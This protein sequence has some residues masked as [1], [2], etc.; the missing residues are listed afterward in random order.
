MNT[1]YVDTREKPHAITRI[2]AEFERRG[3]EIV[4]KKLDVGD[5]MLSPD[6][7]VTVDRKQNLGE[8]CG[9]LTWEHERFQRELRRAT[10]AGVTVYV[11]VEHGGLIRSL[12]DVAGW[13]NPRCKSSPKALNGEGLYKRMLTYAAKYGVRWRFCDKRQTGAEILRL[14]GASDEQICRNN[15]GA[16][17][18]A[19]A[20]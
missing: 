11:L 2:I 14:L 18:D 3:L 6:A 9:N 7:R 1:I 20:V 17:D 19:G 12:A 4:H 15:Q 16:G 10:L 8:V 13:N 5:Y